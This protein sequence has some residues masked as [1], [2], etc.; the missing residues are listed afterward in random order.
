MV[1][2]AWSNDSGGWNLRLYIL[3]SDNQ[4]NELVS[5]DNDNGNDWKQGSLGTLQFAQTGRGS[6]LAVWRPPRGSEFQTL[7]LHQD[8][9]NV[10]TGIS[11]DKWGDVKFTISPNAVTG[12][13]LALTSLANGTKWKGYYDNSDIIRE[14]RITDNFTFAD[15]YWGQSFSCQGA[16]VTFANNLSSIDRSLA[17]WTG[18][19]H[20][21]L[22][23][24]HSTR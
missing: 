18:S 9:V 6:N 2:V 16:R 21:T 14:A 24:S 19:R 20:P 4:V 8:P 3:D 1:A 15:I 22:L 13:G 10:V 23:S 11:N 17:V 5:L 12:S 7:L